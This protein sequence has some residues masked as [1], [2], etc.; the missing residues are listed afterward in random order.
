MGF[1][2]GQCSTFPLVEFCEMKVEE[3]VLQKEGCELI[4]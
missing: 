4:S 1:W 3:A 2:A